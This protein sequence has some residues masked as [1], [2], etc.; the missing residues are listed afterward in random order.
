M[1]AR[2]TGLIVGILG[3]LG[4]LFAA[5]FAPIAGRIKDTTGTFG[6]VFVIVG[7]LPFLGLAAILLA[8]GRSEPLGSQAK[9]VSE[10]DPDL[11]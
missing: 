10:V 9:P 8:W 3:G 6:P 5:G 4:N 11:G 2:H 1:D 7:L